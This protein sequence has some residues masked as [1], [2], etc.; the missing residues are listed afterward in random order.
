MIERERLRLSATD[1]VARL[2]RLR[3]VDGHPLSYEEIV[4]P[5]GRLPDVDAAR[6]IT[7]DIGELAHVQGLLGLASERVTVV[8]ASKT[9]AG[10]RG[11][12]E[13]RRIM[14]LERVVATADGIPVEW[15]VA[16][17]ALAV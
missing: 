12:A 4:L 13:G 5:L 15:R 1:M 14:R 8:N 11:M 10:H 9:V 2:A 6:Q 7:S 3:N 17:I 16:F